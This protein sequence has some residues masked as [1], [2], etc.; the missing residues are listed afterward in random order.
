M[1]YFIIKADIFLY[2]YSKLTGTKG[3]AKAAA[4]YP[5]I[6]TTSKLEKYPKHIYDAFIIHEL[7]HFKQQ[8]ETLYIGK[9][10]IGLAEFLY[11]RILKSKKPLDCYLLSSFEQEAYDNMFNVNYLQTRKSYSFIKYFKNKSVTEIPEKLLNN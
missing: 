8:I 3:K 7:I 6:F 9:I 5:F 10:I 1:K 4:F 2:F 11:F